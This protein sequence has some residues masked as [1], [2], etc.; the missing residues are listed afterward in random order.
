[1]NSLRNKVQL[2]GN[3]GANPVVT[4]LQSGKKVAKASIATQDYY[5]D[6]SGEKQSSTQWHN[7]VAWG[8]AAKIL[9]NYTEKGQQIAIEGKLN[10][11]SYDDK[12]GV[13]RYVTEIIVSD[14]QLLAKRIPKN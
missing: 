5:K 8:H 3:L 7:L 14:V 1:M 12:Q 6:K 10:H 11:R 13:T 9:E 4:L 2:I